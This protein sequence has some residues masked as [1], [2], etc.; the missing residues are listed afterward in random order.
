MAGDELPAVHELAA[1]VLSRSNHSFEL[2]D[3]L[4]V[5]SGSQ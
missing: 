4:E 5:L 2:E 3:L 1:A